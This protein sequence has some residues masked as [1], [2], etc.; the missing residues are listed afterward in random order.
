M[1]SLR[2]TLEGAA[3][4]TTDG[5]IC[6]LGTVI[7]AAA[8]TNSPSLAII[9]GILAGV[10]NSF[11]N[12]VGMYVSQATERGLQKAKVAQGEKTHVHSVK[13]NVI[14]SLASFFATIFVSLVMVAPFTLLPITQAMA[15]S[16]VIGVLF[17]F[18]LGAYTAVI[19]G[20]SALS[21]GIQYSLLG[22]G[23]SVIGYL[24]GDWLRFLLA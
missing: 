12:G 22:V 8:A 13:E 21:H 3:F 7:G 17:L 5:I 10:S 23:G 15:L 18:A 11:A 14:N 19:S 9:A 2:E 4:G 24:V 20:E 16:F 6:S 1:V